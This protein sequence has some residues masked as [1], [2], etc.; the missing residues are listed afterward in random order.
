MRDDPIAARADFENALSLDPAYTLAD[1]YL[2]TID[3]YE[4][5]LGEAHRRLAFAQ[6]PALHADVAQMVMEESAQLGAG[7]V[8]YSEQRG[9]GI[10]DY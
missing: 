5:R 8:R 3:D 6:N 4:R 1:E 10:Q 7:I 2:E 9:S